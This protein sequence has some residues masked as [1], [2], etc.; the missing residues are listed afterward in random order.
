MRKD[1]IDTQEIIKKWGIEDREIEELVNEEKLLPIDR[2]AELLQFTQE[3]INRFLLEENFSL[4]EAAL[5][6]GISKT[7]L[8]NLAVANEVESTLMTLGKRKRRTFK[9]PA[10]LELKSRLQKEK[11]QFSF[12][13]GAGKALTLFENGLCLFD[14]FSFNNQKV[15]V[16]QVNPIVLLFPHG[17]VIPNENIDYTSPVPSDRKYEMATGSCVFQFEKEPN[18]FSPWYS[19]L[20]QL[21]QKMGTNN[22]KIH[23][24]DEYYLVRCRLVS[25]KGNVSLYEK[26]ES[27]LI[28]GKVEYNSETNTIQ[29][30]SDYSVVRC[31]IKTD[32]VSHINQIV[33]EEQKD[34]DLV[35]NELLEEALNRKIESAK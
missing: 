25:I 7:Y 20:F 4:T 27:R 17:F 30:Y 23:E 34:F 24:M 35:V 10:I 9:F 31:K 15:I 21:I 26:L 12:Q 22:L 28:S 1:I 3:E 33:E 29:L 14:S 11:H 32:I 8:S 19:I 6:A 18:I 2:Q 13:R 16:T 5:L